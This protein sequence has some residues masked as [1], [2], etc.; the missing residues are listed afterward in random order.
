MENVFTL[1]T[2]YLCW[3]CCANSFR[4]VHAIRIGNRYAQPPTLPTI[5]WGSLIRGGS[6]V[7]CIKITRISTLQPSLSGT[8]LPDGRAV[9][10]LV[11]WYILQSELQK[12]AVDLTGAQCQQLYSKWLA[13]GLSQCAVRGK[14][15]DLQAGCRT[16]TIR[17]G[18]S[19]TGAL[20]RCFILTAQCCLVEIRDNH[21][22]NIRIT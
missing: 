20:A 17:L 12:C 15:G 9:S 7:Q 21:A 19:V 18:S 8:V 1:K 16:H 4:F 5:S 6:C 11:T 14:Q 13:S 10:A 22:D 3:R 2:T